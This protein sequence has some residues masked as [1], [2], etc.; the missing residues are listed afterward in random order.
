MLRRIFLALAFAT[1]FASGAI[2]QQ[3]DTRFQI[4]NQTDQA[5]R[6]IYIDASSNPQW[7]VDRLGAEVLQPGMVF[8]VT[9][10]DPIL[11]DIKVVMMNG[12]EDELRQVDLC[13]ISRVLVTSNGLKVE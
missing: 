4:V 1:V 6:E 8:N 5:V 9:G 12:A 10:A 2:A 7:T 11:Q 3:C 13:H